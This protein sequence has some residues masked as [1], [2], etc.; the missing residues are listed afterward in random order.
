M[1]KVIPNKI[2]KYRSYTEIHFKIITKQELYFARPSEFS[3]LQDCKY[4]INRDAVKNETNRRKTYARL[5]KIDD[6]FDPIINEHIESNPIT[7]ELID[8]IEEAR[9]IENDKYLGIFSA[10]ESYSNRYLWNVFAANH[11]GFCVGIDYS[12]ISQG[13][14]L[15]G[16]IKYSDTGLPE[17]K[18]Y[19][20]EESEFIE[21]LYNS[22]MTLKDELSQEREY[23]LSKIII[24][25]LDRFHKIPK[26]SISEIFLGKNMADDKKKELIKLIKENLSSTKIF[27]IIEKDG[28]LEGIRV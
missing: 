3:D 23:R 27:S 11:T 22:L 10:S 21:Y 16:S 20:Y 18:V 5:F 17:T 7:D 24:N 8:K 12:Q 28:D 1:P 4:R 26:C 15:N 25:D 13:I 19:N 2:Y 14:G 6:L 9:Q